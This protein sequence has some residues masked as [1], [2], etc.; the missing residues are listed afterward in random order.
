MS[1]GVY[2]FHPLAYDTKTGKRVSVRVD[3]TIDWDKLAAHLASKALRNRS[4]K[5]R[6]NFGVS[7]KIIKPMKPKLV[8]VEHDPLS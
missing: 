5:T 1:T 3:V 8:S 4:G 7:A 6:T 2:K